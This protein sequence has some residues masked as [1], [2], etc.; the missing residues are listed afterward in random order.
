MECLL[1][2]PIL[3]VLI[4]ARGRVLPK[5]RGWLDG[6]PV[7]RPKPLV[8]AREPLAPEVEEEP[9]D[10]PLYKKK[11]LTQPEQ[12]LY[13]RLAG[14]LPGH[15]VLAQVQ[16]SR[17]LGVKR[18]HNYTAWN[19]RIN[20]LSADFVICDRDAS[21]VAVI[22]LDDASHQRPGRPERDAKKDAALAGAGIRVIRWHVKDMPNAESI[23]AEFAG[24]S[25]KATGT[26]D[27]GKV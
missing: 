15:I 23:R 12:V 13:H 11:P 6:D 19:N 20:R 5:L 24:G 21:V 2:L 22:E 18:G 16:L 27:E 25:R 9:P 17:F 14:A 7:V 1:V 8:R 3:V 10:W 4:L 26:Q